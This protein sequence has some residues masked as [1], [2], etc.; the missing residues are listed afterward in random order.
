MATSRSGR[1][2][3]QILDDQIEPFLQ[4][5]RDAG[6]AERTLRKKRTVLRA[7]AQWAERKG[8]ATCDLNGGHIGSDEYNLK[9]SQQRANAVRDYLLEQGVPSSTVTAMGLGKADP[10]AANTTET[11]RPRNRRVEMVV[12]G[13]PIGIGGLSTGEASRA[14]EP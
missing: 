2:Q 1:A 3:Q 6:Y 14:Q 5:L 10:V 7:F 8:I 13:E 12:S 9:L 11:G 4:K